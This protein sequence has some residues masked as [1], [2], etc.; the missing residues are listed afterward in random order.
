MHFFSVGALV[1]GEPR[2]ALSEG[3]LAKPARRTSCWR[4]PA[5]GNGDRI[6]VVITLNWDTTAERTLAEMGRWNPT[7]GY[8]FEKPLALGAGVRLPNFE[9]RPN[10]SQLRLVPSAIHVL[11][12]HGSCGWHRRNADR[13]YFD[14]YLFLDK[15]GFVIEG[16][17]FLFADP[18]HPDYDL[19]APSSC[20]PR[21]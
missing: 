19:D 1:H 3:R 13:F 9:E 21:S 7:T 14:H 20:I 5:A 4:L 16:E 8:G 11:K 18:M 2:R 15:F 12:L 10:P 6:E 17:P